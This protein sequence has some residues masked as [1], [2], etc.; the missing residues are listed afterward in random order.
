MLFLYCIAQ[1]PTSHLYPA[2]PRSSY[3]QFNGIHNPNCS[4]LFMNVQ[5]PLPIAQSCPTPLPLSTSG[6]W[7]A[8]MAEIMVGISEAPR[9]LMGE[10]SVELQSGWSGSWHFYLETAEFLLKDHFRGCRHPGRSLWVVG[11]VCVI[12]V[13][14]GRILSTGLS[15]RFSSVCSK[16][17][18]HKGDCKVLECLCCA[19]R[20]CFCGDAA[21]LL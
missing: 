19:G 20:N 13:C 11:C 7:M 18:T 3:L 6:S 1:T 21:V 12:W 15:L 4:M 8:S 9:P 2:F 5:A 14:L 17:E 10:Q 16:Y